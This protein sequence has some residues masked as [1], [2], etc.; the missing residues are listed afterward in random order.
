MTP[1]EFLGG[2]AFHMR[3]IE[4]STELASMLGMPMQFTLDVKVV[5]VDEDE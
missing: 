2:I 4:A 1:R 3:A 5:E